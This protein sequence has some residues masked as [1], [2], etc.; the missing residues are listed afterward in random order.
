[1]EE[2]RATMGTG[3][4]GSESSGYTGSGSGS[5][6]VRTIYR[7]RFKHGIPAAKAATQS[8]VTAAVSEVL[9]RRS[10]TRYFEMQFV[11]PLLIAVY[12]DLS[13]IAR[14][15]YFGEPASDLFDHLTVDSGATFLPRLAHQIVGTHAGHTKDQRLREVAT[16][17]VEDVFCRWVRDDVDVFLMASR[18][19]VAGSYDPLVADSL[20][21]YF[22]G[23]LVQRVLVRESPEHLPP[24]A[25]QRLKE[26]SQRRADNAIDTYLTM[27]PTPRMRDFFRY[28]SSRPQWLL[29]EI[30]K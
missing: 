3:S 9:T 29:K 17:S 2:V 13:A 19:Q 16:S 14:H 12:D 22:L 7:A 18:A 21:G 10:T 25:R 30:A 20:L 11:N 5:A 28:A 1:M 8:R 6:G 26:E 24:D 15:D 27:H 4:A 23:G